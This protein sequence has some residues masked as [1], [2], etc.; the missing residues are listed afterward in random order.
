MVPF[1]PCHNLGP[2]YPRSDTPI[3]P[4][5]R[6]SLVK[7]KSNQALLGLLPLCTGGSL[8]GG[9]AQTGWASALDDWPRLQRKRLL[10]PRLPSP[11][12][13]RTVLGPQHWWI[14]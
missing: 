8:H 9:T 13:E 14:G 7:P 3:A 6:L 5:C 10:D 1:D 2:P 11:H 4:S 12:G